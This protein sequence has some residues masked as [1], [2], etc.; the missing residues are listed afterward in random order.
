[1]STN[2][3]DNRDVLLGVLRDQNKVLLDQSQMLGSLDAT[4]KG[5][6]KKLDVSIE[7]TSKLDS[8]VNELEASHNRMKGRATVW[9]LVV[10]AVGSALG[11]YIGSRH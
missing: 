6:D 5:I 9:G 2:S 4:V 10:S 8:R 7:T 3:D 11:W 1:M